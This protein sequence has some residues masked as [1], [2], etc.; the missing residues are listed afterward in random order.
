MLVY[1]ISLFLSVFLYINAPDGMDKGFMFVCLSISLF[2]VIYYMF[3]KKKKRENFVF[4]KVYLRHTFL[5]VICFSIVFFQSDLDYVLGLQDAT[6]YYLWIN[7][8]VVSKALAL[9]SMAVSSFLLGCKILKTSGITLGMNRQKK[10]YNTSSKK[11]LC[12]LAYVM[13]GMYLVFVPREYL[14]GGY[15]LGVARGEANVILILLQAVFITTFVLYAYEYKEKKIGKSFFK[16]MLAPLILAILYIAVVLITGR[17]TEAIRMA[18]LLLIVYSYSKGVKV[19]NKLILGF[20]I[21]A[22]LVF[23]VTQVLRNDSG[24]SIAQ[25]ISDISARKSI[26]PFTKEYSHSV[27]TLHVAVNNFPNIIEYNKGLTFF[28]AFFVLIPGLDRLYSSATKNVMGLRSEDVITYLGLGKGEEW[29]MGSS[30]V[31]DVYISFGPIGV[32]IIFFLLGMFL[33]YLEYGTFRENASPFLLVMSFGCFSQIMFVCRGAI[34]NIFLSWSYA[35]IL[36]LLVLGVS[37]EKSLK[38]I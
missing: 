10:I 32:I 29:G 6:D 12:A 14:M 23:S 38:N 16:E 15:N 34:G 17:R 11:Y 3:S 13:F 18:L 9:S 8:R 25:G 21:A 22:M 30:A 2:E 26:S 1:I 19:N 35:T 27:N 24:S 4:N 7:P 31:A 20:V 5:F 33:R 37:H 28:P 36:L